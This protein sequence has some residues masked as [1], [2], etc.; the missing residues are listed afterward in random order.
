MAAKNSPRRQAGGQTGAGNVTSGTTV[1]GAAD[2][3]LT[4]EWLR[5]NGYPVAASER[6]RTMRTARIRLDRLLDSGLAPRDPH[7][8]LADA[9][10]HLDRCGLC[11]CW[12][13]SRR[14]RAGRT[15]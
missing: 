3:P 8:G 4:E 6:A 2:G 9:H 13:A 15:A 5:R 7:R 10:D 1:Q 11:A 14:H 12:V